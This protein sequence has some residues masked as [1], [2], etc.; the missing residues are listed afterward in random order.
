MILD[1]ATLFLIVVMTLL[2]NFASDAAMLVGVDWLS[3]KA[4]PQVVPVMIP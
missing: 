2:S 3:L 1:A 4:R